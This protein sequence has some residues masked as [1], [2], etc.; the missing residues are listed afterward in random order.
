MIG[1]TGRVYVFKI[2]YIDGGA[3][4]PPLHLARKSE[5]ISLFLFL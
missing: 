4:V 1:V 5:G 2:A 3:E